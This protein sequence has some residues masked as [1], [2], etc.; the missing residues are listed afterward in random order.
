MRPKELREARKE[1]NRYK[2]VKP[3]KTSKVLEQFNA[4]YAALL[5]RVVENEE[6]IIEQAREIKRLRN[7]IRKKTAD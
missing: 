4:A 3:V 5:D 1:L 7:G 2:P 6:I